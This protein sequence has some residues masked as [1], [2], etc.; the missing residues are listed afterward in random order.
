MTPLWSP[1]CYLQA[2][3]FAA[4]AHN[5]QLLPGSDLPYITH[6]SN[7]AMEVMSAIA[8]VPIEQPNL[9]VQCALLH[10]TLEDTAITPDQLEAEFGAAVTCGVLALS[11]NPALPRAEQMPDSLRRV[12]AQPTEVWIV[13]LGDRITNLQQ[14]PGHWNPDKIHRYYDEA[15]LIQDTLKAAHPVLATRL[16]DKIKRYQRYLIS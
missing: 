1:D 2:W 5:G 9:A 16:A 13:K 15:I 10:D 7:V 12:L 3:N 11:K 8:Q 6:I 14:P 4:R